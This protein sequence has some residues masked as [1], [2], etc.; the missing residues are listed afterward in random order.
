MLEF[1]EKH[2]SWHTEKNIKSRK[3]TETKKIN[4][5]NIKQRFNGSHE[6]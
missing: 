1:G 6:T 4:N 5:K 2:E 3:E